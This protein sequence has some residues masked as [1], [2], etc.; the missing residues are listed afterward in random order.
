MTRGNQPVKDC[1]ANMNKVEGWAGGNATIK[2]A[3]GTAEIM[4]QKQLAAQAEKEAAAAM[5]MAINWRLACDGLQP[6]LMAT[7]EG[8]R[9]GDRID[10]AAVKAALTYTTLF[11]RGHRGSVYPGAALPR[12]LG[13]FPFGPGSP[14]PRPRAR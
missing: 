2:Q 13:E 4:C 8:L 10:G 6:P 14:L 3:G 7:L 12:G 9:P 1:L 5:E 11:W